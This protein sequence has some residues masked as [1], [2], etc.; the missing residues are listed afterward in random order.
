MGGKENFL[1]AFGDILSARWSSTGYFERCHDLNN[2]FI[3]TEQLAS[4]K[5]S[6]EY[7]DY[8]EQYGEE[9]ADYIWETMHPEIET[10]DVVYIKIDG[11]E[12]SDSL[13]KYKA[14]IEKSNK[15]LKIV[16]GNISVLKSLI[17]G[18]WDDKRFL[19]IP[20]GKKI[21]GVYDMDHVMRAE[22]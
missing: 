14:E 8:V 22:N 15:N 6:A 4:Y 1:E 2:N 12:Y 9:N 21:A 3:G 7:M 19:V 10:D 17:N 13:E 20:P 16:N 18:E 5:T 11:F